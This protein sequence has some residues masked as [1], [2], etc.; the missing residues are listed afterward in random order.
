MINIKYLKSNFTDKRGNIIDL[1]VNQPKEHCSLVS[2]IDGAV[3]GNHYHKK[4]TQFTFVL[5]GNFNLFYAKVDTRGEIIGKVNKIEVKPNAF[6]THEPFEAHS[7]QLLDQFGLVIAFACGIRG[8]SSYEKDTFRLK[9][10][11]CNIK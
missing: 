3:R 1:F 2:F 7:F 6:I 5:N 11:M 4:S 9:Q 8:G 10:P